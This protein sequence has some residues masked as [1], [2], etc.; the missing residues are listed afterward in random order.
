MNLK[1]LIPTRPSSGGL[2]QPPPLLY[3]T[4]VRLGRKEIG[5]GDAAE[6][7]S[8]TKSSVHNLRARY[9]IAPG[10]L[11]GARKT[12]GRYK[13]GPRR[14]G[15][16]HWMWSPAARPPRTPQKVQISVCARFTGTSNTC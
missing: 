1:A 14:P 13:A 7:L 2:G 12:E 8:L 16:F 3:D 9:G 15:S 5:V 11:K 6:I 4:L 10:T